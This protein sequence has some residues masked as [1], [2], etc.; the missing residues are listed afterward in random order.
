[1]LAR[2]RVLGV[3]FSCSEALGEV[4]ALLLLHQGWVF[5]AEAAAKEVWKLSD[6]MKRT[7]LEDEWR[8]KVGVQQ[9]RGWVHYE[10]RGGIYRFSAVVVRPKKPWLPIGP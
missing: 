3:Q 8:N 6:G 1:M 5:F 7:L 2:V 9:S 4:F 10:P